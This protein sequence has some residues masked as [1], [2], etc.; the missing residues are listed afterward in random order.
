MS[1]RQTERETDLERRAKRAFDDSV[2]ALDAATRSRL[3]QARYRALQ[4]LAAGRRSA[5][6][7][8]L[9]LPTSPLA[10]AGALAAVALAALL[11][12]WRA[13][14][15]PS[16][17]ILEGPPVADLDILLGDEDLEMLDEDLEFYAWLEEQPELTAPPAAGDGVG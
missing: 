2:G 4:E 6:L 3:T 5:W 11:L 15:L 14:L 10:P 12:V 7:G 16:E 13:E 8:W 17:A 9:R 1:E